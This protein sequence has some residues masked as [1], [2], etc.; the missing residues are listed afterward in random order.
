MYN[1]LKLSEL[2]VCL[3]GPIKFFSAW[4]TEKVAGLWFGR[5][6]STKADTMELLDKLQ[7]QIQRTVGPSFAAS[8]EPWA[9]HQNVASLN[10]FYRVML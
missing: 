1:M 5:G 6:I 8:L 9:H 4:G 10:L 2:F 3:E 7:K